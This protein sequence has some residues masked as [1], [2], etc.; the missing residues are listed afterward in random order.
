MKRFL[1]YDKT[2]AALTEYLAD[3]TLDN[4]KNA[5]KLVIASASGRTRNNKDVGRFEEN[6]HEEADTLMICLAVSA[7]RR[8][9]PDIQLTFFLPDTDVLVL[10]IVNC[11]LLPVQTSITMAHAV[12]SIY[13]TILG[14]PR[15]QQVKGFASI[16]RL[17]WS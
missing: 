14:S 5:S 10:A 13:Q 4:R 9:S 3:K 16:P 12:C 11:D 17:L 8:N 2:K 15:H 7:T 1:S 6:N